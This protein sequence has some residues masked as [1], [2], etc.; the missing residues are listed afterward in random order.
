M[1]LNPIDI[2]SFWLPKQ[3]STLAPQVDGAY[4]TVLYISI[5]FFVL[6][7]TATTVFAVK[8]RRR[9]AGEKTSDISHSTSLEITWTTIPLVILLVLFGM[10]LDGYVN[11]AVAPAE[12]LEVKV[13]AEKW[14]WTFTYPNGTTTVNELGVPKDRPVRLLMS[15]K[16]IVHSFFVPEFRVKQDVVPGA[17]TTTWFQATEA[18]EVAVLCAEYCGTGHSDML[19]KVIVMEDAKFKDW[20]DK[21]GGAG[22]LPPAELGKKLFA[23][24]NCATCHSLDGTRIQGPSLKGLFGRTEELAD[25][26]KVQVDE[27]YF[28]ES[29]FDP[30]AK[31]VKGYPASMPVFKGLLKDKE[32]DALIAYLKTVQ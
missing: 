26:S 6:I 13:T 11:A 20:L 3:S 19:A 25:G 14:L 15:S 23:Q 27:N 24:R 16:D 30:A 12:A 1:S 9:R 2:G 31:V 28:R 4:H 29:V 18:K 32:V 17:Y 22:D 5:A 10:G 7:I 21:G 8:Y